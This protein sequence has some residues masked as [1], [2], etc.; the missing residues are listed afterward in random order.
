MD[1]LYEIFVCVWEA[2]SIAESTYKEKGYTRDIFRCHEMSEALA[3]VFG[4]T[5]IDG[6]VLNTEHSW[7]ELEDKIIDATLKNLGITAYGGLVDKFS[8][9]GRLYHKEELPKI[10]LNADFVSFHVHNLQQAIKI[11]A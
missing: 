9:F 2:R 8:L 4:L 5:R 6:Y 7:V 3:Q 10:Q 11:C 1:K